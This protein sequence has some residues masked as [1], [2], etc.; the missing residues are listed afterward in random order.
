MK[1]N[2]NEYCATYDVFCKRTGGR[3]IVCHDGSIGA[4]TK[5]GW[6]W[7]FAGKHSYDCL[8]IL[9]QGVRSDSDAKMK[10]IIAKKILAAAQTNDVVSM[11]GTYE[12]CSMV[13]AKGESLEMTLIANDLRM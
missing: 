3:L 7:L 8:T 12:L 2:E 1:P 10:A 9:G 4:V 6:R 5:D 11:T 13:A